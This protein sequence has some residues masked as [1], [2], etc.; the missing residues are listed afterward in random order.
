MLHEKT[1]DKSLRLELD[2]I[3]LGDFADHV[4]LRT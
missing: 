4:V 1:L 2:G 3:L